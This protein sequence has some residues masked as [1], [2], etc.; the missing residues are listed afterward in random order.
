MLLQFRF[1]FYLKDNEK[2][3][4]LF[5]ETAVKLSDNELGNKEHSDLRN[6]FGGP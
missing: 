5:K 3:E 1:I 2:I 6:K 4:E